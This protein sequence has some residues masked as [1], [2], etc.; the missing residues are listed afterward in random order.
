MSFFTAFSRIVKFALVNFWRNIWLSVITVTIL[1]LSLISINI[2]LV[3]NVV[4]DTAIESIEQRIDISVYLE[5]DASE[6]A[7]SGVRSYLL[8]LDHVRD[9]KYLTAEDALAQFKLK[10]ASDP[11]IL[12][13][14]EEVDENPFGGLITIMAR[15]PADFPFILESLE[16]PEFKDIIRDKDFSSYEAIIERINNLTNR[17]RMV[18]VIVSL[19]FIIISILIVFN[20]IRVAIYTH[21]EEIGIMKLVG[22]S[23]SFVQM[24]FL[25]EAVLYS[26]LAT[27]VIIAILF[28]LLGVVEPQLNTFFETSNVGLLSYYTSNFITLFGAQFLAAVVLTIASTG[29]AMR[30]YLKV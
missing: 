12:S 30:K 9:I 11:Q 14:L 6:E 8:A 2:L 27:I 5:K 19:V 3:L 16:S 25:V 29:L 20:T 26:L 24:P 18:G 22:A 10:H 23:N 7:V 15:T 28:P 21:R 17:I 1:V 13:S 4:T